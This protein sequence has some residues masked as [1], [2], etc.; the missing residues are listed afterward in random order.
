MTDVLLAVN[1]VLL[2]VLVLG[3]PRSTRYD[4]RRLRLERRKAKSERQAREWLMSEWK[5][6]PMKSMPI[7]VE[8]ERAHR[9]V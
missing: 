3:V 6:A 1:A 7:D 5:K 2:A 9:T 4:R 8:R